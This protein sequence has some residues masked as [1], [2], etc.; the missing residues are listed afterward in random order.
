MQEIYYFILYIITFYSKARSEEQAKISRTDNCNL[1]NIEV[2][3]SYFS[4]ARQFCSTTIL[5]LMITIY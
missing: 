5:M 4:N 3:K 1:S 2:K